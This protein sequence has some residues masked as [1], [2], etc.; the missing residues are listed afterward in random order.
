MDERKAWEHVARLLAE[1]PL[2]A[3][4][5]QARVASVAY[6]SRSLESWGSGPDPFRNPTLEAVIELEEDAAYQAARR[7]LRYLC[8]A[9]PAAVGAVLQGVVT[10]DAERF[11]RTTAELFPKSVLDRLD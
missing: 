11:V 2:V 9:D 10:E 5:C 8:T 6:R 7:F 1:A 3:A 4:W